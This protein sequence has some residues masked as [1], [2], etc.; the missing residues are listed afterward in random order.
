MLLVLVML[1]GLMPAAAFAATDEDTD[2]LFFATD[3]HTNTSVIGNIINNM[4]SSIGENE[5]EY[6]GLGGDMVGSGNSHPTYN[7]STVLGEVTGAT[8]S[9]KA[10]NVDIVA[11]IHDM[12]VTDDS[13]I[14]LPYQGGGAQIYEGDRYYVYGV[15]EYCISDDSNES[16]WSSEAQ[17]FVT[18]ANGSTI[19]KS[20]VIIVLSHYP[21]HANRD[22]NDGAYYWHKALNTVATGSETGEEVV[23]N[24][25]FFHG[26]NH[27]V[28]KNEYVYDVGD[29]MTIQNGSSTT[30]ATI[31]YTYAT[32]GY[33]NQNSKATLMAITDSEITLTKYSTSGS[34]TAM[35]SVERVSTVTPTTLAVTGVIEYAV[36]D[37]L[38]DPTEVVVTYSDGSEKELSA[39][40]LELVITTEDGADLED[41]KFVAAG[42]YNLTYSYT[43][44]NQSASATLEVVVKVGMSTVHSYADDPFEYYVQATA[45]GLTGI[46]ATY[47]YSEYETV[48][49]DTFTET[50]TAYNVAL[51]GHTD[52]NEVTYYFEYDATIPLENLGLYYIDENNQLTAIPFKIVTE[53]TGIQYIEFTTTYVG[54]FAYGTVVVPDGYELS[55]ITVDYEGATK[56]LVG[57]TFDMVHILVTAVYTKEG[58]DD[59]TCQLSIKGYGVE[60]GYEYTA[61]SMTAAG[62]KTITVTY[63]GKSAS[64][65]IEVYNKIFPDADTGVSVEVTV[66]GATEIKVETVPST[67]GT[68]TGAVGHLLSNYVA[69]DI[70]LTGYNDGEKVT[71]TLPVPEGV[72]NPVVY[73]VSDDGKTIQNMG[74]AKNDDGTVSFETDHFSKYVV[75]ES[76]DI[77]V[78]DPTTATVTGSVTTTEEKEVYVLVSSISGAG[79]YLIVNTNSATTSANLLTAS[80]NG[81]TNTSGVTIT[82]GTDANGNTVTYIEDPAA[83]AIWTAAVSGSGYTLRNT[84]STNRYLRYS[85]SS[86]TTSSNNSTTWYSGTNTVYKTNSTRYIRYNNGWTT[87]SSSQTVYIYQKQTVN[88]ATTTTVDGTYS[89][90]GA[91]D[92]VTK[93]VA[94]DG[95]TTVTLG[96]TLTFTPESGDATTTDTST[97]ATYTVVENGDPNGIISGISGNTVT[98]SGNY[99]KALVKVSYTGTAA[100]KTYTVDNYIVVTASAPTYTLD[101]TIGDNTVTG[102]TVSYKGIT[103]GQTIALGTQIQFVDEDG[104]ETIELPEGATLEWH[105]PEE[106]QSIATVNENGE[107]TLKGVD[108]AFYV[109]AT[110]TVNGK[111]YTVGVNFSVTTT[112]YSTPTDG[113][114]DFPEYP[115]EGAVRFDKTATAVGNFSETGIAQVELSMTGVPYTTGSEIDVVVMLDMTGSMSDDGME[116][117][118]LATIAFMEKIVKNEDGTYNENRIA[119]YAFNSGSSSPYE[120]VSLK[121]ITSDAE[122]ATATTA[123]KTA[124]DKQTSGGT[125]FDEAAQKCQSVL[126]AA[127]TDG[128]GNNRQQFCVFMSDGGPTT[129]EGSDG[130]TYYG[131]NASGDRAITS[132]IGG[133]TSS[134]S[135]S[136]TYNL[137]TEYYTDAMKN[138]GV[139]VYTVGLLLQ[140]APSNPAPYSSMTDSTMNDDNTAITTAGSHY[141]FTSTILKNMASDESKYIDIFDVDNADKATAA[142]ESIAISIL[143]AATDI[144]VEDKITDE[145]TMIFDIPTGSKDI[146]GVTDDFYIEF[147]K[148][149]LDANHER[150]GTSTSMTKLYLATNGNNY[151]AASDNTGTAYDTPVFEKK[152]I[153]EKGTLYFWTTDSSKSDSGISTTVDGTTYYFVPYGIKATDEGFVADEWYNMTSGAYA[154]GTI[155]SE[156]NMSEDLVIATPYFV[157]NAATRML[158]WTVDKLDTEEYAL[159]YFLYLDNSATEVGTDNEIDPG[160][161]PTNEYAYL[162]YTNFKGNDCRQEMPVPQ[163]TWSGAQV[164]YV[165]YLVNTAGQ[166]IN[167][168]GQVVDFANATFITDIYTE[169]TV[170]NKGEDGKITADSKLSIDWLANELLPS[171]Y[172][173]YDL[174]AQYQLHVYGDHTGASIFD[175]FTIDGSTL[176][177]I[178]ASLNSRL[179]GANTTASSVSA[180]TTKVYNTKAGQKIAGYGTYTSKATDSISGETVLNSFDFYDT[181]VAFAVVWQPKLVEDTVVVDFGLDV[182]I[183]VVENDIL[184]NK[185]TGIGL[186]NS[187]YG[188]I[189][190]NTG[191]STASKLGTADLTIDGHTVRIENETSIRFHQNNMTFTE[192]VVFYYESPVEFY[193][194]S[195]KQEGYMYSK[196]TVIPATSI[197]YEDSFVSESDLK[198]YEWADT[199]WSEPTIG[200]GTGDFSWKL[201]GSAENKTQSQ[202]RPGTKNI[203]AVLDANNKYGYD[204]AYTGMSTHSMGSALKVHVDYDHMATASFS[205]YG[206]GFDLISMTSSTTGSIIVNVYDSTN[207]QVESFVVNTYY[208]M[209][210]EDGE[211]VTTDSAN[212]NALYQVPVIKVAGLTYGQYTAEIKVVYDPIFDQGLY[213]EPDENGIY[214]NSYDFYLDAIRIYDPTGNNNDIANDAYVADGEGW[215]L[216][217]ELRNLIVSADSFGSDITVESEGK[218]ATTEVGGA[219]FI[220]GVP[221]N[222]VI[223]DYV[224]YG[225]N[226]ELYLA[227]GQSVAFQIA[228]A[229]VNANG[230]KVN[231]VDVQLAVKSV[232]ATGMLEIFNPGVKVTTTDDGNGTQT[233]TATATKDNLLKLTPGATD[234]Y[235]SIQKLAGGTIVI[236][237][238]ADSGAT[239]SITN[240]KFTFGEKAEVAKETTVDTN[241]TTEATEASVLSINEE[242]IVYAMRSLSGYS[243]STFVHYETADPAPDAT[244]PEDNTPEDNTLEDN[245][246][247]DNTPE[248][249]T[250]EDNTP[251][252]NTPEDNTPEDNTPEDNTP[253]DDNAEDETPEA[254]DSDKNEETESEAEL[255]WF[256]RILRAIGRFF[257]NLF[258]W[259]FN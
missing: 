245:T 3:R 4:E 212:P 250:P 239:I 24:I 231:P 11:G 63:G 176:A 152:V 27:T 173:V 22:D 35:T 208:G 23:R 5:L 85:N 121:K 119:V 55:H 94:A 76:T 125:P 97:T 210:Y 226:N 162:T 130:Y 241:G 16:N 174:N 117:A 37:A 83:A 123:I 51:E 38:R 78:P 19:D 248:D 256:A 9:L 138:D 33:L 2:Y 147:L 43:E 88:F 105:I 185:V 122:L 79:D 13:G 214:N 228:D 108:G 89:I 179:E 238:P 21:L 254:E 10:T 109:T 81:V 131:G 178:S 233:T 30:S 71:V 67:N 115:N 46:T 255:G 7:S 77:E 72:E 154:S 68:V 213:G 87:S 114:A 128:T 107:V 57:D 93:V 184:Q 168:S 229:F 251:E 207:E 259:I 195:D 167:K 95:T 237:N 171:D 199:D 144:V 102:T 253:E 8:S 235:Y 120:L 196:V 203:A 70:E 29:S 60:D 209:T 258:G 155:N 134:T 198:T 221:G 189:A 163:Q 224:S 111:D 75:G 218:S 104:A 6:L 14:V 113:T 190:M 135:S 18:W 243:S 182:L 56:Y 140:N 59:F 124:S 247:E 1:V 187:A 156:T 146:T 236:A 246:P 191:V 242:A 206:T 69:Y 17:K 193:E 257:R 41:G 249:N 110:L 219:V 204:A 216:Y 165:F 158:Y 188:N 36:G 170:W 136:W 26:H 220:D 101:I 145:Y 53:D 222:T 86:F 91:P 126:S 66:P 133:Y 202:D 240:L 45:L 54:V 49:A 192:P 225:P 157:Y 48:L 44:N 160:S 142:F 39:S 61:P 15:E 215:P 183:N 172:M 148:Y 180:T 181:T 137:P 80:S 74:A 92:E 223:K 25:V 28:D 186:G 112:S 12:N 232:Y 106:Y 164:S 227:P 217:K 127:K 197:Y 34:G 205:F 161:Y 58:C 230:D 100:G 40:D 73:Y 90:E 103:A 141:Y 252:D 98:F 200:I 149:T 177:E 175:Y 96:S 211:W 169:S 84:S 65:D 153:G 42:T 150:T 52:G 62:T 47:V 129:Y 194:G 50:Y 82:T 151:Y 132:Y 244:N 159:R 64:F 31:R 99:G 20:K 201:D 118:E 143:Q 166:P 116:A 32:A 234:L 139:T